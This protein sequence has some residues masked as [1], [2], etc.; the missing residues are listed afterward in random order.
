MPKSLL[1]IDD[2]KTFYKTDKGDI[3][4]VSGV[5]L[6]LNKGERLGLAGES[7]CGKTTLGSSILRLVPRPGEIVDGK[8]IFDGENLLPKDEAYMR[9]LRWKRIAM[10]FQGAMNS[11][12]PVFTVGRQIA[13]A[14]ML[15]DKVTKREAYDRVRDLLELVGLSSEQIDAYPHQLSG[16]MKQRAVIAMAIS[17]NPDLLIAD[18]PTTALDVTI[19]AQIMDLLESLED[20][21]GMSVLHITHNLALLAQTTEKLAIM[22]AGRIREYGDTVSIF[23]RPVDP[24]TKGLIASVPTVKGAREEALFSI[25]GRPPDLLKPPEGCRFWPRCPI[26]QDICKKKRPKLKDV[27]GT[28]VA[29]HFAE[30]VKGMT[31]RELWRRG[32]TNE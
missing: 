30:D 28:L 26:A 24:Y 20:R 21:Y 4:A 31:A 14:I 6:E 2:L 32:E 11:L 18:E 15:H 25:P 1:R 27:G 12:N 19:Q 9:R 8:L 13:E 17:L 29:C 5:N 10:V 22:Y 3:K 7:G 23:K 16:G